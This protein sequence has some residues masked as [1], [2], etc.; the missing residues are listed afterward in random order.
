M[1][2]VYDEVDVVE[3][4]EG[5]MVRKDATEL[6]RR[7]SASDPK[8]VRN[9]GRAT[10]NAVNLSHHEY[11]HQLGMEGF[12]RTLWSSSSRALHGACHTQGARAT[13]PYY[14]QARRP[15]GYTFPRSRP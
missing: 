11:D 6:L 2:L 1:E 12:I 13:L 3:L 10:S 14:A 15:H 4:V 9:S 8:T 7:G 5:R